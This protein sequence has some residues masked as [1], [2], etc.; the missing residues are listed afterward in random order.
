MGY[1]SEQALVMTVGEM[2]EESRLDQLERAWA[3]RPSPAE[4]RAAVRAREEQRRLRI[5]ALAAA[6]RL[7]GYCREFETQ[8]DGLCVLCLDL[9]QRKQAE[10]EQARADAAVYHAAADA[11]GIEVG[12]QVHRKGST[13]MGTVVEVLNNAVRVSWRPHQREACPSWC[14]GRH[15]RTYIKALGSLIVVP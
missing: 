3:S 11:A 15:H 6:G 13:A 10:R 4:R 12:A 7:C 2:R 1:F 9:R 5:D 8:A 14:N